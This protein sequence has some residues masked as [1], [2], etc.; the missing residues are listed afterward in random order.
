MQWDEDNFDFNRIYMFEIATFLV[1]LPS[2]TLNNQVND[3]PIML[4]IKK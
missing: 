2:Q 4:Y 1:V 3:Q